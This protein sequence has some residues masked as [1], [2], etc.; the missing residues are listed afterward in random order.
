MPGLERYP[1]CCPVD[2]QVWR[3]VLRKGD[4]AIDAT[5]GNGHDTLALLRMVADESGSGFIY[6]FDIQSS[7]IEST[8]CLLEDSSTQTR[9]LV[10][11]SLLCHSKM[12]EVLQKAPWLVAFN[13]GYLP[14]GGKD[15][16]TL[17]G[18]TL[19]ALHAASRV[20]AP[21]G[22]IS[23]LVYVGHPDRTILRVQLAAE[24]WSCCKLERLNRP[25]APLLLLLLKK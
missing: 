6:G 9:R 10:K 18:T 12:E 1:I 13:L 24:S 17:P 25:S 16:I 20:L 11:L 23:V 2:R 22:L 7:A 4:C 14:G 21:G 15:I 3:N 19:P 8:R 5:C